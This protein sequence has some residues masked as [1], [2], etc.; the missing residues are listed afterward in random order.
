MMARGQ[1]GLLGLLVATTAVAASLGLCKWLSSAEHWGFLYAWIP[2]QAVHALLAVYALAGPVNSAGPKRHGALVLSCAVTLVPLA[3][4]IL[5]VGV[6]V[7]GGSSNVVQLA[8]DSGYD[9]WSLWA[10][11]WPMLLLGNPV[12]WLVAVL[13]TVFPPYPPRQW[14]S[15]VARFLAVLVAAF[16]CWTTLTYFPDA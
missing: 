14:A 6:F 15:M 2:L 13:T 8:G 9:L 5:F 10:G 3:T 7:V 1:Y 4:L 11:T 16:A 12:A